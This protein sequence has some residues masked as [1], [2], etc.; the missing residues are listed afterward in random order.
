MWITKL[1]G[2]F[3][4]LLGCLGIHTSWEQ[5]QRKQLQ[6]IRELLRLLTEWEHSLLKEKKRLA[7]FLA[8]YDCRQKE[9]SFFLSSFEQMVRKRARPFGNQIWEEAL[10]DSE[11]M[12]GKNRRIKEFMERMWEVFF[13]TSSM[14]GIRLTRINVEHLQ[15]L[16]SKEQRELHQKQALYLKTGLLFGALL[17][18][19][20]I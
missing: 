15:E 2:A 11:F 1:L 14:E 4:I 18:I 6:I 8:E 16:L 13:C 17:V 3:F 7:D 12:K 9:V 10:K 5:E 20:L 19:L